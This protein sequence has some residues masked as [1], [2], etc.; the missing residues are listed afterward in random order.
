MRKTKIL[1]AIFT[2]LTAVSLCGCANVDG[3]DSTA[4]SDEIHQQSSENDIGSDGKPSTTIEENKTF[5]TKCKI[6]KQKR[7]QFS[8]EQLLSFF[9]GTTQKGDNYVG[10]T[11]HYENDVE[12]G[13][14]TDGMFRYSTLAGIK[15]GSICNSSF[16]ED[17]NIEGYADGTLDFASRDETYENVSAV[18]REEFGIAQEEFFAE[19][20]YAVKKENVDLYKELFFEEANKPETSS[21][22]LELAKLKE[23]AEKLRKIP[24]ED[25]YYISFDFKIDD[26]PL[27]PGWGFY[28]GTA[29]SDMIMGYIADIVY[30]KN[31]I[32]SIYLVNVNETDVSS[33]EEVDI[34]SSDEAK[35]LMRQKFDGIIMDGEIETYDMQFVY[36]PIPQND[37]GDYF[38]NFEAKP[39]YAFYWKKTESY[40]GEMITSNFI[41]YFDAVTGA[42]FAVEPIEN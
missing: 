20:F 35:A 27:Y 40:N 15:Y 25:Y 9:R 21:N 5:P 34:I 24:S 36:L 2:V 31:G 19:K 14:I 23:Q 13:Y 29:E 7:K 3:E 32:E 18:L 8:E 6:Y 10:G 22:E 37:L 12:V 28:F 33:A 39:F 41:S 16:F 42:E 30:T 38:T 4:H 1:T 26:I 11:I 17:N